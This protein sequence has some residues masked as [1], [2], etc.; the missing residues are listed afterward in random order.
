MTDRNE[1]VEL[2]RADEAVR[3]EVVVLRAVH[4]AALVDGHAGDVLVMSAAEELPVRFGDVLC[5]QLQ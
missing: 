3:E 2:G 5:D 1:A 4:R